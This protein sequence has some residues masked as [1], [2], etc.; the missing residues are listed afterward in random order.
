MKVLQFSLIP[1]V[2][3]L[4]VYLMLNC[5]IEA[6]TQAA[7]DKPPFVQ[8]HV[9][10]VTESRAL[11]FATDKGPYAQYIA[12]HLGLTVCL[13]MAS[14]LLQHPNFYHHV[15]II[16]DVLNTGHTLMPIAPRFRQ[17]VPVQSPLYK[18]MQQAG[19]V[20]FPIVLRF[21]APSLQAATIRELIGTVDVAAGGKFRTISVTNPAAS[22]GKAI[23]NAALRA[24]HVRMRVMGVNKT[25]HSLFLTVE[26][27]APRGVFQ[28]LAVAQKGKTISGGYIIAQLPRGMDK[29]MIPLTAAPGSS[30][31]LRV[32]VLT[33]WHEYRIPFTVKDIPLPEAPPKR[34]VPE[35]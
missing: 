3:P 26:I 24:A 30:A 17:I 1:I 33:G 35:R 27:I 29:I 7:G 22:T 34:R 6:Q 23:S 5:H 31:V 20:G 8:T 9:A 19:E 25:R 14:K 2:M 21:A 4:L 10:Y 12:K 13:Q 32:T 16:T 11:I 15:H 28:S 18:K